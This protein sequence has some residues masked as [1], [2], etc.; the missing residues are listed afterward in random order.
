L[1]IS[2]HENDIDDEKPQ[3][4]FLQHLIDHRYVRTEPRP[5]S[6]CT[7]TSRFLLFFHFSFTCVYVIVCLE[8]DFYNN[9]PNNNNNTWN[10]QAI[11]LTHEIGRRTAAVTGDPLETI[12][13]FQRL[14]IAIQQANAVLT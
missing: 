7:P 2:G 9:M 3:T 4:V 8:H 13:L 14:S 5:S 1:C 11:E 10:A 12:H 6:V